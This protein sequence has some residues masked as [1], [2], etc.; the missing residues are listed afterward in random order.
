MDM[1]DLAGTIYTRIW[2]V[3]LKL[4]HLYYSGCLGTWT[5]GMKASSVLIRKSLLKSI[6]RLQ[7]FMF[8]ISTVPREIKWL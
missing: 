8:F 1:S 3:V 7:E 6:A 2:N 4:K 5:L